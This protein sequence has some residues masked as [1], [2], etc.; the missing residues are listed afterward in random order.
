MNAPLRRLL[1]PIDPSPFSEAA[2][3]TAC[4]VAKAH[5]AT[6]SSVAVL[7]SDDIRASLIPAMGPY[8]PLMVEE[9]R[10]KIN[11][12]DQ[13][14]RKHLDHA[15]AYCREAGVE[16][17]ETG[18]EGLP[19]DRL[20]ASAIFHDLLVAGME[21]SFHFETRGERGQSLHRLLE[22]SATPVLAVPPAGLDR[23]ERVLVAFDGSIGA[24]RALR[25]FLLLAAPFDPEIVLVTAEQTPELSDFLLGN[26]EAYLQ[27]HGFAKVSRLASSEPVS[28]LF[29]SL[30]EPGG[31]DLVVLGM[32]AR[33]VIRDLFVG[34]FTRTMMERGDTALFLSH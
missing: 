9:I 17:R 33:H 12:A 6:V 16:H 25:D 5:Q 11:H 15:A 22:H 30:L 8:Y 24:A 28:A 19:A 14:L 4:F 27:D 29:D 3:R 34:N 18:Y 13:V 23:L 32:R 10:R 1:V 21:T 31:T 20:M 2:L 26:A 7:D